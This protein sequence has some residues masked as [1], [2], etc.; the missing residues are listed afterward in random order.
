M[1][2][3]VLAAMVVQVQQVVEIME[4]L[5]VL[6]VSARCISWVVVVASA[7]QLPILAVVVVV[8]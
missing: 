6:L 5:V 1:V 8:T 4:S 3:V 2:L 7:V